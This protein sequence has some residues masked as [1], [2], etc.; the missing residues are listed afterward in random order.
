MG[1]K[2]SSAKVYVFNDHLVRHSLERIAAG[3]SERRKVAR[4]AGEDGEIGALR[5]GGDGHIR[6]AR[7]PSGGNRLI[8]DPPGELAGASVQR[9]NVFGVAL[10]QTVEPR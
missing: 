10:D 3:H 5:Q 7:M 8:R 1:C 9:Q 6:K 4:V 2:T